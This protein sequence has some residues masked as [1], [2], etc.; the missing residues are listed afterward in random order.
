[1][2]KETEADLFDRLI[3]MVRQAIAWRVIVDAKR[4]YP[5]AEG[6]LTDGRLPHRE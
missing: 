1:M 2:D 6:I 3:P 5:E 4:R